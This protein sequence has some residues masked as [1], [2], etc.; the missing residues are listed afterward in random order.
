MR[1]RLRLWWGDKSSNKT[2]R[3]VRPTMGTRERKWWL[4]GTRA[5]S[6]SSFSTTTKRHLLLCKSSGYV[7]AVF[8]WPPREFGWRYRTCIHGHVVSS[9]MANP[10]AMGHATGCW[11]WGLRHIPRSGTCVPLGL[12]PRWLAKFKNLATVSRGLKHEDGAIR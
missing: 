4:I 2:V 12:C 9:H 3:Q 7:V 5:G 6:G 8:L 10:L 11:C 1:L